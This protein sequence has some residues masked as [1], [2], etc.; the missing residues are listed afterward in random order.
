M[1]QKLLV[2]CILGAV[3][4]SGCVVQ[5]NSASVYQARQ[6]QGEQ[7]VRMGVVESLRNVLIEQNQSGVGTLGGE[8]LA[9][10]MGPN[11]ATPGII[12]STGGFNMKNGA[13]VTYP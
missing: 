8:T 3:A 7:S 11:F 12:S 1:K 10:W 2:T 6:T 4:L 9:V 5:P 13:S